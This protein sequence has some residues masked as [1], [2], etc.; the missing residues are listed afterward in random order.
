MCACA[1]V[2]VLERCGYLKSVLVADQG[3]HFSMIAEVLTGGVTLAVPLKQSNRRAFFNDKSL[4][5]PAIERER[6]HLPS[7]NV[8]DLNGLLFT[9]CDA[10]A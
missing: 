10:L 1:R 2:C 8:F 5:F 9:I 6:C 3:K 7:H 4:L